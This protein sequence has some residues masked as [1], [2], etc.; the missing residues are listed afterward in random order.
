MFYASLSQSLECGDHPIDKIPLES[1]N[2][3]SLYSK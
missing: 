2:N 1:H 3:D